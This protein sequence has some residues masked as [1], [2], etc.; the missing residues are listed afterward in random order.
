M[1]QR[2]S[3]DGTW[4]FWPDPGMRTLPAGVD[5][6]TDGSGYLDPGDRTAALG[7][8]RS[9]R[10]PGPWQAQFD[11][12]RL[13]AGI[14]WYER[15]F[16]LPPAWQGRRVWLHFGAVD[17]LARVWV[18]GRFAGA[19]EGGYL[20]FALEIT[21]LVRPGE[22][23]RVTVQVIDPPDLRP[24]QSPAAP[25]EPAAAAGGPPGGT[26]RDPAPAGGGPAPADTASPP[27]PLPAFDE[28]PHGKQSWYGPLS[29]IWQSV[30]LEA[31]GPV[32]IRGA[33]IHG[34]LKTGRVQVRV[35]LGAPAEG[36]ERILAQVVAPDGRT[37]WEQPGPVLAPGQTE[38]DLA[39][40]VANPQPWDVDSPRLYTLRLTLLA[41]G[42]RG[43]A[44]AASP[45]P[46]SGAVL[47]AAIPAPGPGAVAGGG[48]VIVARGDGPFIHAWGAEP[49]IDAWEDTFGFRTI[50]V[51][52]GRIWLNG[53]PI[54]LLGALD[55]DYYPETICTPPSDEFL[56]DQFLRAKELGLNLLRCHIKVPDPRYLYWADRLGL[57]VW[58]ELPSWRTLTPAARKR[59]RE[60]LAGMV[61]R[62]FNHPSLVVWTIVNEDWGTDLP[63]EPD[64]R[65]WLVEMYDWLKALDPTRLVVD[66][67]PCP[68]NFH[69]KSD[70]NDFHWYQALP[71]RPQG[72]TGFTAG[73]VR[74]PGR[75]FS[76]H[77][78][79]CRRGDEPLVLSEFGN[80]GLPD[81]HN[82]LDPDGRE[83]WWFETGRQW[84]GGVVHPKGVR[85]R[86]AAWGLAEVFGTWDRFIAE[87]QEAEFEA[88]KFEIEDIRRHGEIAGYVITEFTDVHWECNGLLDL[89]RN[90]KAFHHR[91][92]AINAPDVVLGFPDRFRYAAG[93]TARVA[94]LVSHFSSRRLRG[95]AVDWEVP[96][97]GL[98]GRL[99]CPAEL[100]PAQVT[101]L[102]EIGI[103]V[104]AVERPVRATLHLCLRARSGQA[105]ARNWVPLPLFPQV[106][107]A[108]PVR[109]AV[110]AGGPPAVGGVH[111][112]AGG[113]HG[114]STGDPGAV[115]GDPPVI[116]GDPPV[117]VVT[118]WDPEVA[119]FV[120]R[121]GRAVLLAEG[122]EALP[123]GLPLAIR[124]RAG[125][126]WE[127]NWAQGMHW[128]H[129]RLTA[130]LGL[131]PR[132][133]LPFAGLVP[134]HVITGY[135]AADHRDILGGY[136]VGWIRYPVATIAACRHG[137]GVLL[138]CT[139]RFGRHYGRDPLATLMVNRLV[140]LARDPGLRPG[141]EL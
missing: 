74:D 36:G 92:A 28:I 16:S 22:V 84:D 42:G 57:L 69:V 117:A 112:A 79:G 56:R 29:G 122:E 105:L 118:R 15:S 19:H 98:R 138:L 97:L 103:P 80:W 54:Y 129:P 14:G 63:G 141:R 115:A 41:P 25:P 113:A 130:D 109:T 49:V 6:L 31:T 123:A 1:R 58:A 81:V 60:T 93:E 66:N 114:V 38:V 21:H 75:T 99:P 120:R 89:A 37:T 3:L 10:V 78:D 61:E 88:L 70:L 24:E 133:D 64:H 5:L 83:P 86:F 52:E 101:P 111:P 94:V 23:S 47:G 45:S 44:G 40:T 136:Y 43:E 96:E 20:P 62:D 128:L 139:Y 132:V 102:G 13:S 126:L 95:C 140:E 76:P 17:Y 18:N 77:G 85:E 116:A 48:P 124:K 51:R 71:D 72:W 87:S 121:G 82:L 53:R 110:P 119:A 106:A 127:G 35:R 134:E 32:F 67:S 11:D 73:W 34:C 46:G 8:P 26:P 125:S 50:E 55:Q 2:L 90:P 104:P 9:I 65:A 108:V 39:L 135:E 7:E 100:P 107:P 137:E 91:F 4:S 27:S 12:L 59:A 30:W 131:G 68:P 33:R